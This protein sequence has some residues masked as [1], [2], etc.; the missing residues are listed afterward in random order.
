MN[1]SNSIVRVSIIGILTNLALVAMKMVVGLI[2][3]SIAIINDAI[4]NFSDAL[5]SIITIIGT[6]LAG[7]KPDKEHP[8]GHGRIEYI[9]S[10]SIAIIVLL[11]GLSSFTES[12]D[13]IIH[14]NE[15]NY[16]AATL[17]VVAMGVLVKYFLGRYVKKQGEK[18]SS[19]SLIASGT[20]ASFDAIISLS[21]LI[22]AVIY[23]LF[24]LS[25]EGILGVV[26][27]F[28]ILKSGVE[29]LIESLSRIIGERIEGDL[30][31]NIKKRINSFPEVKGAY[32][33]ILHKYGP[34]RIIG[35]VHIEV[36]EEMTAKQ[37][38]KLTREISTTCY[39]EFGI[40]MTVGI[41]ASNSKDTMFSQMREDV[42]KIVAEYPEILEIHAFYVDE[43]VKT[44]TFDLVVDFKCDHRE[45]TRDEVVSKLL[46]KYP[47]Y[48]CFAVIDDDFSD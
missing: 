27:S 40:I 15:V 24:G 16:T 1:R 8:Y 43:A 48:Q 45:K 21:T 34:E 13:K 22:A 7:R 42:N 25:L 18:Y 30:S 23:L 47:D 29:I 38:H 32:D 11:A 37:L 20:D 26:I 2:S 31:E 41:Y 33:L 46:A 19:E 10:I 36:D 35:S 9:S 17:I 12:V 14:P 5:S 4:N 3:G 39:K 6:K 44:I 28:F